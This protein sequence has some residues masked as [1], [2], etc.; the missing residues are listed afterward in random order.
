MELAD[1]P[2]NFSENI[3]DDIVDGGCVGEMAS[4][5]ENNGDDTEREDN[6]LLEVEFALNAWIRKLDNVDKELQVSMNFQTRID[7][8][9]NRMRE[10]GFLTTHEYLEMKIIGDLWGKLFSLL[11][12]Y[13]IGINK[14]KR[15]LLCV[16]LE[17]YVR[18]QI[19]HKLYIDICM[20]I[21]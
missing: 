17:L 9:L 16:L 18:K 4:V 14:K 15:E 20:S 1:V 6:M 8:S 12:A 10:E 21:S 7:Q 5:K 3:F 2:L 13:E 11:T 19:S